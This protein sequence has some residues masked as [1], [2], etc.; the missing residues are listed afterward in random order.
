MPRFQLIPT[1]VLALL[2]AVPL[3]ADP[4]AGAQWKPVF[5]DDFQGTELDAAKW[6][7]VGDGK[8][9]GAWWLRK[10]A[11]L[12]GKGNLVVRSTLEDGKYGCGGLRTRGKFR[13]AFGYYEIR[14][15]VPRQPGTWAA[16]WL[17]DAAQGRIGNGGR[18][19]A[20]IDIFESPW[21]GKNRY[22]I[23]VHWDGYGK[24]HKSWSRAI[25][26]P[27]LDDDFH[28]F[29]LLWTPEEYVFYYDG[30][31]VARTSQGGVC[32]VPL[33][34]KVTT[35][36]GDWAGDIKRAERPDDFIVDWA[37]V[38]DRV[39]EP[40]AKQAPAAEQEPAAFQGAR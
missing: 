13:H 38:W 4:P 34:I 12:D 27:G 25:E 5:A 7:K 21:L 35:E 40:A 37:R 24:D 20:E 31:E 29:G 33:Y 39:A 28:V 8:R 17:Y 2:A 6:E 32:Q 19:G 18:D 30:K 10:N 3:L 36:I 26:A 1:P 16:F 22:N 15:R 9:R 11:F 14:C 23:A